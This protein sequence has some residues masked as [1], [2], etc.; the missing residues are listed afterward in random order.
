MSNSSYQNFYTQHSHSNN[1]TSHHYNNH[2]RPPP[3]EYANNRDKH[4]STQHRYQHHSLYQPKSY[5]YVRSVSQS[6]TTSSTQ[7]RP[8]SPTVNDIRDPY[9][10]VQY[11]LELHHSVHQRLYKIMQTTTQHQLQQMIYDILVTIHKQMLVVQLYLHN[12]PYHP[13]SQC[14]HYQ[15]HP[16]QPQNV[17]APH[18]VKSV[19]MSVLQYVIN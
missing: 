1:N 13:H 4:N 8:R 7:P 3:L 15:Q 11:R 12:Q 19:P 18:N 16:N 2:S 17:P 10:L 6:N 14:H 9:R 5:N